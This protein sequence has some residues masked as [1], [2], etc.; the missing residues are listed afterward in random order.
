MA[1]VT[2]RTYETFVEFILSMLD[3]RDEWTDGVGGQY[4]YEKHSEAICHSDKNICM[5]AEQCAEFSKQN[6]IPY[7]PWYDPDFFILENNKPSACL[8]VTHW[9]SP[10]DSP[11]KFW[12]SIE[13]H[14]QYKMFFGPSFLSLNLVF[15]ALD[16]KEIPQLIFDSEKLISLHGW[17]P[18]VGSVLSISFDGSILF[19][20]KLY[21][22]TKFSANIPKKMP[23]NAKFRREVYN[24][25][26]RELYD[27]DVQLKK[28]VDLIKSLFLTLLSEP[29]KERYTKSA[30]DGLQKSCFEGRRKAI[31]IH[32]TRSRYRKGIQHA[33]IVFELAKLLLGKELEP[34]E[35]L[36]RIL[37]GKE[38][39]SW[40]AFRALL[41]EDIDKNT[42]R[43]FGEV[44]GT[45]P[46][47][48]SKGMPIYLLNTKAGVGFVK[49][50]D[51]FS[52]FILG[53]KYLNE[54]DI[55]T[56]KTDISEMFKSYITKY[57]VPDV[58]KDL[59]DNERLKTKINYVYDNYV[60]IEKEDF[61]ERLSGDIYSPGVKANHQETI[62]D[63]NNWVIEVLMAAYG[64]GRKQHI[65]ALLPEKFTEKFSESLRLYAYCR[66]F[67]HLVNHILQGANIEAYFSEDA[68]MSQTVFYEE[69]KFLVSECLWE[70]IFDVEP[71][72]REEACLA[73]KHRKAMRIV[74]Q[75]DLEPIKFLFERKMK[76]VD[77][78]PTLKGGFTQLSCLKNWG[79]NVLTTRTSGVDKSG[80]K[81]IQTQSV[82][83][84]KHIADKTRELAARLRS[85]HLCCQPSGTF[86]Q[87]KDP[88][89]HYLVVDGDW[90][91]VNKINLMEAGFKGI[92]EIGELDKLA[93]K[94]NKNPIKN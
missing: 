29:R 54:E 7:G 30:I 16:Q 33:F 92:F 32:P 6:E 69:I 47:Q 80:K 83:G 36:W 55:N 46:I 28:E 9:T 39:F 94:L 10:S 53:L 62:K 12:R 58:I 90:P 49:W 70:S 11:R 65:V 4:L 71:I 13:D 89:E 25:L 63:S 8:H 26:W 77:K 60:G 45:I 41:G 72:S 57:G 23:S 73:Y 51:D 87:E 61:I 18:A 84:R 24:S 34:E 5:N 50:N 52:E 17:K 82:F 20:K 43:E 42:T 85:V 74:S 3:F 59:S 67:D 1:D 76:G 35:I 15:D 86:D 31:S 2:G 78:G 91:I 37:D 64:L 48:V 21:S 40:E 79:N 66:N 22:L 93:K 56:L 38:R 44:L 27:L 75:S 88:G 19:P 81:I 14:L 68:K